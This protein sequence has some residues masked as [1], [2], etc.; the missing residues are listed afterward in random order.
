MSPDYSRFYSDCEHCV[1]VEQGPD[2][3]DNIEEIVHG[4]CPSCP[5]PDLDP[6]KSRLEQISDTDVAP[7]APIVA[8]ARSLRYKARRL[9]RSLRSTEI[10]DMKTTDTAGSGQTTS[11]P[12]AAPEDEIAGKENINAAHICDRMRGT[13]VILTGGM[14]SAPARASR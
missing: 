12:N 5:P 9:I 7:A 2:H 4:V 11:E 3:L 10:E 14:P 6:P 13:R 1:D 8:Y